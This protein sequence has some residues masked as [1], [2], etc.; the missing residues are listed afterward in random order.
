[1]SWYLIGKRILDIFGA[2]VGII[3]FSPLMILTALWIKIVSPEGPILADIPK[4][5]GKDGELFRFFKFRSM[6]PNA[7]Q[8]LENN[9]E[10]FKKYKE[11]SYKLESHE[12]PRL[13]KGAA[14]MRKYSLDELPQFFNVLFGE[15]SI[16]GPRA[17]YPK[18]LD[19]QTEKY[20]ETKKYLKTALSVK[21]GITGL[22]QVSGRSEISFEGRIRLDA[23]YA[24][25]KSIIFDIILILKTPYV[26]VTGK[27]AY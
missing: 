13:I 11:N 1:M 16:V 3:L 5:V 8:M 4:R 20:P 23:E 24:Q 2:L 12:D 10:L 19:A 7:Q 17:Y 9:P 26:V 27:G 25:K 21:P 22:W 18:E 14:F 15:M 6:V